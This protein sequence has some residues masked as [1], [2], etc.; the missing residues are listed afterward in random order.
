MRSVSQPK[1]KDKDLTLFFHQK[2]ISIGSQVGPLWDPASSRFIRTSWMLDA[3]QAL[4]IQSVAATIRFLSANE[5]TKLEDLTRR[6]NVFARH[7]WENN[8]YLQRIRELADRT[9]I[10]VIRPGDPAA[11][12]SEAHIVAN[13]VE[14]VA[15]LS[16]VLYASRSTLQN[17]LGITEHRREVVDFTIGPAFNF[18]R[19]RSKREHVVRGV[20][21]DQRFE[22]RFRRLG[23]ESLV[24]ESVKSSELST[25]LWQ[26]VQWLLESRLEPASDAAV[27]KTSIALESLLGANDTEPL[28]ATLSE[29]SAFLLSDDPG[30]RASS[31][32]LI[33]DF[34]DARSRVV[35]GS[36]KKH[37]PPSLRL[38]EAADRVVLMLLVTIAANI[39]SFESFES[40]KKWGDDQRWGQRVRIARP[41]R[42]GDL[43]RALVRG[44]DS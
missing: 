44:A 33:R 41:F 12:A 35:H 25:R 17:R 10:E 27:I 3:K 21:V 2:Q 34:Y 7:S 26:A 36:R 18:L 39:S 20:T 37:R 32:K 42:D 38:I 23:L 43:K 31:S 16:S 28:R 1:V 9:V 11:I 13:A 30:L 15:V 6:R 4:P 5:A 29:R 19:S 14:S 40:L 22:R 8:F 24:N